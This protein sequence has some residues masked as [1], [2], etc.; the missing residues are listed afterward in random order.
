[1]RPGA[2]SA[3]AA[4]TTDADGRSATATAS[5]PGCP[6]LIDG[7]IRRKGPILEDRAYD[8]TAIER[9]TGKVRERVSQ[10]RPRYLPRLRL[11]GGNAGR[12]SRSYLTTRRTRPH[13]PG[14]TA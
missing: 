9:G 7:A 8:L 13:S 5:G 4:T 12:Y 11:C 2:G 3:T 10:V 14:C 6:R 1:M